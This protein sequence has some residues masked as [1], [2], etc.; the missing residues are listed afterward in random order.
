MTFSGILK[1]DLSQSRRIGSV[2]AVLW[3]LSALSPPFQSILVKGRSLKAQFH[4]FWHYRWVK[5]S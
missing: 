3:I 4:P 1:I 2:S 5:E